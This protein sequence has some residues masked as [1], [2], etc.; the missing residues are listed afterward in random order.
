MN[1]VIHKTVSSSCL[2]QFPLEMVG[3][4]AA[5]SVHI[6]RKLRTYYRELREADR[7]KYIR[8]LFE[9]SVDIHIT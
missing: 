2:L 7:K 5:V 9:I 4:W 3:E 6:H 8:E 1:E